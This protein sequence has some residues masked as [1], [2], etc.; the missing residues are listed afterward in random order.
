MFIAVEFDL[1]ESI[2]NLINIHLYPE[3]T[4]R[5]GQPERYSFMDANVVFER[6]G[7]LYSYGQD[8]VT[9]RYNIDGPGFELC[10]LAIYNEP[11]Q[12]TADVR[13]AAITSDSE[14][15]REALR[16]WLVA[17]VNAQMQPRDMF[18]NLRLSLS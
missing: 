2:H 8:A 9:Y 13:V 11:D 15:T 16:K 3:C 7:N 14:E 6:I 17:I 1:R 5:L 12:A 18:A 10:L 4:Y